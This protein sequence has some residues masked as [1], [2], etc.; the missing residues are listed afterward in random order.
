METVSC[1]EIIWSQS[2]EKGV[3]GHGRG[4]TAL[5]HSLLFFSHYFEWINP[6]KH[7]FSLL[8]VL[9][10]IFA[11]CFLTDVKAIKISHRFFFQKKKETKCQK[12]KIFLDQFPLKTVLEMNSQTK[13]DTALWFLNP[14]F[15]HEKHFSCKQNKTIVTIDIIKIHSD[16]KHFSPII[17]IR[18]STMIS[19]VIHFFSY[20][21]K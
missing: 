7:C 18:Y 14:L 19:E 5:S 21:L 13:W 20:I 8:V 1:V 9:F 12:V 4:I 16:S 6:S 17:N 11:L 3:Q 2:D 15:Y 10:L